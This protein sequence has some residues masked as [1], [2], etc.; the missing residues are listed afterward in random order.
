MYPLMMHVV[1]KTIFCPFTDDDKSLPHDYYRD[2][3]QGRLADVTNTAG[4]YKIY[5]ICD[6][7]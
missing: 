2:L 3:L 5:I 6:W 1:S 7:I 4:N